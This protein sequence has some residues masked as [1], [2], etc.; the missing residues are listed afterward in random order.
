MWA[1]SRNNPFWRWTYSA[2]LEKNC[3]SVFG[4][5]HCNKILK[6]MK[7]CIVSLGLLIKIRERCAHKIFNRCYVFVRLCWYDYVKMRDIWRISN[8]L[9]MCFHI[10]QRMHKLCACISTSHIQKPNTYCHLTNTNILTHN[11]QKKLNKR[12]LEVLKNMHTQR[13]YSNKRI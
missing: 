13:E 6:C 5:I 11:A 10:M 3:Q 4:E 9:R 7:I 12:P 1:W 8:H 2:I